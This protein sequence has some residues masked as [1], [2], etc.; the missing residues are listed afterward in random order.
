MRKEGKSIAT[1]CV[2]SG[3][4]SDF[5]HHLTDSLHPGS[6][7]LQLTIVLWLPS[8]PLLL[9]HIIKVLTMGQLISTFLGKRLYS[10]EIQKQEFV[11]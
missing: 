6:H 5:A 4:R 2:G 11:F 7:H 1:R 8:S 9:T 10:F 3:Q